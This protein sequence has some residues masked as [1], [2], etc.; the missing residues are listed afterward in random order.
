MSKNP[1]IVFTYDGDEYRVPYAAAAKDCCVI[2][3]ESVRYIEVTWA[4]TSPPSPD[5][6]R[7]VSAPYANGKYVY[8]AETMSTPLPKG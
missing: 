4:K 1:S 8:W 6:I 7:I 2:L 3:L 5:K